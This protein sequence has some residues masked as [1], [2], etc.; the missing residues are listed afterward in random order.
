MEEEN[1]EEELEDQID[2]KVQGKGANVKITR[3]KKAEA[4]VDTHALVS[5]PERSV[6]PG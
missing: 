1:F 4:F 5:R 6:C 3:P 2:F